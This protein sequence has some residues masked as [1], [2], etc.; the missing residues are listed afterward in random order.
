MKITN[1][2]FKDSRYREDIQKILDSQDIQFT[3]RAKQVKDANRDK[4]I[5]R[6]ICKV[7]INAFQRQELISYTKFIELSPK[8]S[9][10]LFKDVMP[11]DKMYNASNP[12]TTIILFN[13]LKFQCIS[14][15]EQLVKVSKEDIMYMLKLYCCKLLEYINN[16]ITY[17][18]PDGTI[19]YSPYTNKKLN[20]MCK[21]VYE[22]IF[23][24][25]NFSICTYD[26]TVIN[27]DLYLLGSKDNKLSANNCGG[28]ERFSKEQ[29]KDYISSFVESE[30]KKPSIEEL[31][32]FV[33][34][35]IFDEHMNDVDCSFM[36]YLPSVNVIRYNVKKYGLESDI[37]LEKRGRKPKINQE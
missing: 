30:K 27:M 35:S 19:A 8:C 5:L 9:S 17:N 37:R 14:K 18:N 15:Y 3:E 31:T 28:R 25:K 36:K 10:L 22:S 29:M 4:K 33:S 16:S 7:D 2:L 34:M 32:D 1:V 6:E 12:N 13:A 11:L 21:N 23:E 20:E 24:K 26:G